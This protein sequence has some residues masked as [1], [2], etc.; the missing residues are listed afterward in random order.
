MQSLLLLLYFMDSHG[1]IIQ[2]LLLYI[3]LYLFHES[4]FLKIASS[5]FLCLFLIKEK[6]D[7]VFRKVFFF[8]L[9][10]KSFLEVVKFKNVML[11]VNYIKF[12]S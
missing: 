8:I 4:D 6:L 5:I 3:Y 12:D 9:I 2:L 11:F 1:V 7:L 10:G